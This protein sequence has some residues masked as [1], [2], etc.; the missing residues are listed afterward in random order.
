MR[1]RH[2]LA[3]AGVALLVFLILAGI[4]SYGWIWKFAPFPRVRIAHVFAQGV[5]QQ[6]CPTGTVG[7]SAMRAKNQTNDQLLEWGC[8]DKNGNF[9]VPGGI[10]I[11]PTGA[12]V[13][14]MIA[15]SSGAFDALEIK[16]V[17]GNLIF[18][19][20]P[21]ASTMLTLQDASGNPILTGTTG[22]GVIATCNAT[23]CRSLEARG[24]AGQTADIFDVRNSALT[25]YFG[26]SPNGIQN[27]SAGLKHKRVGTGSI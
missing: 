12:V 3:S 21:N 25:P 5:F 27:D 15:P 17:A 4:L 22:G 19:V 1:P 8:L 24:F 23:G 10:T 7:I 11:A 2:L 13:G 9:T 16:N 14:L 26:V 6:G 18:S 20:A